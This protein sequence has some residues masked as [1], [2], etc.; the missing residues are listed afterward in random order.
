MGPPHQRLHDDCAGTVAQ[1]SDVKSSLLRRVG[2]FSTSVVVILMIIV[3]IV[4]AVV[5]VIMV[6]WYTKYLAFINH[7]GIPNSICPYDCLDSRLVFY[8]N[9]AQCV[10]ALNDIFNHRFFPLPGCLTLFMATT[11]DKIPSSECVLA[12]FR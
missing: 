9:C 7:I 3:V 12:Y 8:C 10:S 1:I 2:A 5:I 11:Y 4:V 6:G